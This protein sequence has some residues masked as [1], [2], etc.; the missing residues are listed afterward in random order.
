MKK[1]IHRSVS[2]SIIFF[3]LCTVGFAAPVN[4]AIR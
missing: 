2:S 4:R 3:S 1:L